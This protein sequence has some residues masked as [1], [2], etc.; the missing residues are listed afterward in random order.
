[1]QN[2]KNAALYLLVVQHA[3][4]AFILHAL[5]RLTHVDLIHH[6]GQVASSG[7]SSMSFLTSSFTGL[8]HGCASSW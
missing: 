4:V 7:S 5:D 2:L 1:M 6:V 8:L 3:S